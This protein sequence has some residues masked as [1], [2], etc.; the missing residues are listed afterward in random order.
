MNIRPPWCLGP[1][2]YARHQWLAENPR[3][4]KLVLLADVTS[5]NS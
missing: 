4:R 5:A 2:A 3:H 1:Q